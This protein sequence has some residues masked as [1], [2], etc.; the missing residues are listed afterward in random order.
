MDELHLSE[1]FQRYFSD[2]FLC[3]DEDKSGKANLQRATEVF[4]SGNIPEDVIAQIAELCWTPGTNYLNKKQFFSALKLVAAYQANLPLTVDLITSKLDLPLPRFTWGSL[5]SQS[6]IPDLIELRNEPEYHTDSGSTDSEADSD[7]V[8]CSPD[9]SSPASDSPTPTNSIQDRNWAWQGL[10]SEEQ[11]QLLEESSDRHSSDEDTEVSSEVWLI[12]PE[13]KDYYTKQFQILQENTNSLL[14]GTDARHFFERSQLPIDELRKIWQLAD[15]T[16]DGALSLQEFFTAMH[17]VVL[18]KHNIPI[19]DVLP[20]A[21]VPKNEVPRPPSPQHDPEPVVVPHSKD[22]TVKEWTKFVDSPTSSTVSSPGIK[23]VNFDFHIDQNDPDLRH[24][25]PRRLT[26]EMVAA[27]VVQTEEIPDAID[28]NSP[29]KSEGSQLPANQHLLATSQPHSAI[30]RPQPKKLNSRMMG[31]IPP[32]PD[33]IG[34]VSLPAFPPP[35]KEKPPPPPP[36][37]FKT[38]GR[39]SSLDLNK[40]G[41]PTGAPTVPPRVSPVGQIKQLTEDEPSKDQARF[42]RIPNLEQYE[43]VDEGL[44]PGDVYEAER[45]KFF[46]KVFAPR[47]STDSVPKKHGAFEVYRKPVSN[48]SDERQVITS[49]DEQWEQFEKLHIENAALLRTCQELSQELA[50]LRNEKT[51]LKVK[52]ER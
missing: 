46:N 44:F 39:S 36:R 31:A 52:L 11:R 30:Q 35:K 47:E 25:V 9:A 2:I 6:P 27:N 28:L 21:L 19:P 50:D 17:L 16:K 20:A 29:K 8:R 32:P 15:V 45:T 38:H 3:C 51:R 48:Q 49:E 22:A 23:P 33:E 43:N 40:L 14:A 42:V 5:E 4:K 26:P 1:T 18:R 12:T 7:T 13:Q 37:P 24:P 41:K 10:V 34:P